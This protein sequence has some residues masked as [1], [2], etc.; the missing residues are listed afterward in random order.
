MA[1][2]GLLIDYDYCCGCHTCEVA[3]QKEHGLAAETW[4]I[5]LSQTGPFPAGDDKRTIFNFVPVPTEL[6]DLCA[7][8]T[9]KGKLPTCV[10]H[11]QTNCMSFGTLE[12]LAAEAEGKKKHA[13]FVP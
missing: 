8:R 7:E 11:C 5:K 6:C 13:I 9:G 3:C 4:G 10:H 1:T 2:Y 12:E